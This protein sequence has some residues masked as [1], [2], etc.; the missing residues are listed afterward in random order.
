VVFASSGAVISG[1]E[2]TEPYLALAQGRYEGLHEWP[3]IT[4]ETPLR[5]AGLYGASKAWGEVLGR[6][7]ADA[8]GLS[9]LCVRIG[10]VTAADRPR[11]PREFAVWCSQRDVVRMI[12]CCLAAPPGLRFDVFF[13]TSRNRWGY[14]DLTHARAV[15][16]FEPVDAAEDYRQP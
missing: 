11:E 13:A 16:G 12:A 9:V 7:F 8:H 2:Q 10:R 14:R 15:V 6:Q 1:W 5:P 3:M 4:H